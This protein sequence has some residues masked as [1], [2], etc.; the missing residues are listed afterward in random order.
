MLSGENLPPAPPIPRSRRLAGLLK[1]IALAVLAGAVILALRLLPLESSLRDFRDWVDQAGALGHL[2]FVVTYALATLV[3]APAASALSLMAG[4]LFGVVRG[5][6]LVVAGATIGATMAFTLARTILR[7]RVQSMVQRRPAFSSIDR[8][9]SREGGK[10][11]FLVRLSPIFPFTFVNYAFGVTGVGLTPYV[12]ATLLGI[13]P[14]AA[15]FAWIGS[16]TATA[17]AGDGST[18]RLVFQIVGAI[19]T[20][21]V[22]ILLARIARSASGSFHHAGSGEDPPDGRATTRSAASPARRRRGETC[23][24]DT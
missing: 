9:V 3:P 8:A 16:A 5:T 20:L 10:I 13:I 23:G 18:L 7:N 1:W 22:S 11:V 4:A 2:V 12:I 21:A 19:A 15:A 14:G 6:L 17:A 24:G